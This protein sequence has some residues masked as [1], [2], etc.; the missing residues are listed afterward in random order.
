MFVFFLLGGRWLELRLRDRTA[1]ALDALLNRVPQQVWRRCEDLSFERVAV[2]QLQVGD[3]LRVHSG[4]AFAA[5]G[6]LLQGSTWVDEAILTGESR[7]LAREPG[8]GVLAGSHNLG[9]SVLVCVTQLGADTRYAGIVALMAQAASSKPQ[10]AQLVDRIAKP[11]LVGVLLAAA[12]AAL[13]WW[14]SSPGHALMVAAAVLIVTCPCALSLAT[15]VSALTAAGQLA[16]HGVLVNKL[17]ALETLAEVDTVVFD[18]TGT[19]S[20][21]HLVIQGIETRAGTTPQQALALAAALAQHALHPVSRALVHAAQAQ[22]LLLPESAQ[23][24]EQSGAGLAGLVGTPS[25][26]LRLGHAAWCGVPARDALLGQVHL[27]DAQGW[28][29]TFA[30]GEAL[31]EDAKDTVAALAQAGVAVHILSGDQP[32]AVARLAAQLG[33]T[34]AQGGCSPQDKLQAVQQ[35]QA[36]GRR[37]A[38]VGDGVNDGPVLAAA[39]VAIALGQGAVL[40][41]ARAPA[42]LVIMGELGGVARALQLARQ[43]R[44]VVRQNLFWA[45]AYNLA[46]VPLALMG[47]LPAWLAG[48][49][50]AAS[51][52]GVVLNAARLNGSR[53]AAKGV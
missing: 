37:V 19:L 14:P 16:R 8:Q 30:W 47:Y 4:E 25:Q 2:R 6:L 52:L 12:L 26:A 31:R 18:K 36:A 39:H 50:M 7:P 9:S 17:S 10:L 20:Q 22:G 45:L 48:L 43:T 28:V 32:E 24:H 1:G 53:A 11:F 13:W 33:I 35:L 15:P 38:M 41:Q 34:H 27:S 29:A 46:C 5:D 44:R 23:V 49:G 3:V 40:A 42:D 21:D 51:S